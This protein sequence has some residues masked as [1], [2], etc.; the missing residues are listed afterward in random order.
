MEKYAAKDERGDYIVKQK[1]VQENIDYFYKPGVWKYYDDLHKNIKDP[2]KM[3]IN[4]EHLKKFVEYSPNLKKKAAVWFPDLFPE[5]K[6][7]K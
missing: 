7:E 6:T 3:N 5:L 4:K 2:D 1:P